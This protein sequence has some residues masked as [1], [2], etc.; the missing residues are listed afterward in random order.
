MS[1]EK[2]SRMGNKV[3]T[4]EDIANVAGVSRTIV[5]RVL[6]NAP[7]SHI[8]PVTKAKVLAAA[9]SLDYKPKTSV[10]RHHNVVVALYSLEY[11]NR[12]YFSTII[13]GI[14]LQTGVFDFDL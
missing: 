7:Q 8:S 12:Y 5:S 6:S 14:A 13:S 9:R 4:Q 10:Q 11:I 1:D 2:P 3:V